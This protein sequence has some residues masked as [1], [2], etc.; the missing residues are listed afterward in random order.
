MHGCNSSDTDPPVRIGAIKTMDWFID[1]L[2]QFD[3]TISGKH[4]FRSQNKPL[5]QSNLTVNDIPS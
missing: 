1:K 3:L 5:F 2:F 4:S